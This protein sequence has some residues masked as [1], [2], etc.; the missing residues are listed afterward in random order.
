M[1]TKLLSFVSPVYRCRD[2]LEKLVSE[3]ET[4]S[5]EIGVEYEVILVDDRCPEKSWD[6]I[7]A[8]CEKNPRVKGVQLSRNFGQ[9][10]AIEAG[11][12]YVTGDWVVVL[13]CDLQDHPSAVSKLWR[14]AQNGA[15]I[16][17]ARRQARTD[18]WHRRFVSKMFYRT[19]SLLTGTQL[20]A[21]IANFGIYHRKVIDSYNGWSEEQK[22]FPVMVQ[23]LGFD[24]SVVDI[25]H[26]ER[27]TGK[28]SYNLRSLLTLG[29]RVVL[30]FSDR[31]LWF[32]S[33]LG[34]SMS[35]LAMVASLVLLVRALAG[36]VD[37][38]GWS[39]LI[40]SIWFI[41]GMNIAAA[42]FLGIYLGRTLREA[43]GRPSYIVAKS[44]NF[45]EAQNAG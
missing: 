23:W 2:C 12:H 34:V 3:I 36:E 20:S 14:E 40:L 39:S 4:V 1:Q 8:I 31:P 37:V 24:Q 17:L 44:I 5:A 15:E 28:S 35:L 19:L 38:E 13:D 6:V 9:H 29:M 25:R 7:S 32:M 16:V 26:T 27:F 41:G 11:L 45:A 30:S 22:Y 33:L 10:S 18:T 21:E 43:K 42:G